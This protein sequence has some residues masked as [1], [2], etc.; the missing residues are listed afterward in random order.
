MPTKISKDKASWEPYFKFLQLLKEEIHK[1]NK[2]RIKKGEK[3]EEIYKN[4]IN[5]SFHEETMSLEGQYGVDEKEFP[6][7]NSQLLFKAMGGLFMGL[8]LMGNKKESISENDIEKLIDQ[9]IF[10]PSK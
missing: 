4:Y 8:V 5:Q 3:I 7:I 10:D 6:Q 2:E 1:N 9:L